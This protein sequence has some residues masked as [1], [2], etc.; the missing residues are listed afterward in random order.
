MNKFVH[1]VACSMFLVLA[2]CAL[3]AVPA[4]SPFDGTWRTDLAKTKFSAKPLDF[5]ISDGWYHCTTCNPVI[6]VQADGVDHRVTGQPFDLI[7]VKI[8]DP[9]TISITTRKDDK[10]VYEQ[11]RTVSKDGK[12]LTVKE[13][14]YPMDGSPAL[15][16]E[17]TARRSGITPRDVHAT[18]GDWIVER[19]SGSSN[20]LTTTY[21]LS[22]NELTMTDPTG[23]SYTAKLN[24]GDFP[25]KGAY[26]WDTVSVKQIN[27]HTIEETDKRKGEVTDVSKLT[28]E[29]NTM[30]VVDNDKQNDRT[31]TYVAHKE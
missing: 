28:V 29:G 14:I 2:S 5:Y 24:E 10:M 19:E 7:N 21:K 27:S 1:Y 23:E 4:H 16:F 9:N 8:V 15:S 3:A 25:V 13:T 20:G 6:D 22:G 11:T 18:S 17:A 12:V 26:G 30:T 31:T